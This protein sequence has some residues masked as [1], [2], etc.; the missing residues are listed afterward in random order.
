MQT[1]RAA[2]TAVRTA[3][4]VAT[5][6][7]RRA[8]C[9]AVPAPLATL[10]T[11]GLAFPE[12]PE[13]RGLSAVRGR[14]RARVYYVSAVVWRANRPLGTA[15]WATSSLDGRAVV[16]SVDPLARRISDWRTGDAR[17]SVS[18]RDAAARRSRR[19]AAASR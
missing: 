4:R 5:R 6:A 7:T 18:V 3:T 14:R 12:K 10:L 1:E 17:G 2:E 16:Y 9:A 8:G 13:L 15:T 11:S 19:C